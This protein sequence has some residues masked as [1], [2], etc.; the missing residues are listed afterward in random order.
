MKFKDQICILY[1][2]DAIGDGENWKPQQ[3]M[4]S[5]AW[6]AKRLLT[7]L[8]V[9]KFFRILKVHLETYNCGRI[10]KSDVRKIYHGTVLIAR[11]NA[12]FVISPFLRG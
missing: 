3:T 12:A 11:R 5:G 6:N 7:N 1:K 4:L 8:L 10:T 2:A 9:L